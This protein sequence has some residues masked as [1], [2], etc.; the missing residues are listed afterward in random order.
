MDVTVTEGSPPDDSPALAALAAEGERLIKA[1]F[2]QAHASGKPDWQEMRS[3]VV[4]NRILQLAP[5]FDERAW[6]VKTFREFL[7]LFPQ[8][9]EVDTAARPPLVRL[10]EGGD[11]ST[12]QTSDRVMARRGARMRIRSDLWRAIM[13]VRDKGAY[14][15]DG[16]IA[17][18]GEGDENLRLPTATPDDLREWRKEFVSSALSEAGR[19]HMPTDQL[20]RWQDE[21]MSSHTLPA[22]I[23][24]SWI[25][26][27][28]KHVQERLEAWFSEKGIEA[29]QDLVT[30]ERRGVA[31][32]TEPDN[33]RAFAISAIE[34][35]TRSELEQLRL[36]VLVMLRCRQ[37]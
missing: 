8:L 6:G 32:D 29:P 19:A 26:D 37:R 14:Y 1:A 11:I 36:P 23:R 9:V 31:S 3:A 22:A 33:L 20:L 25:A 28:K 21:A 13:D 2:D 34:G 10:R 24:A 18:Q 15:W 17:Q 35:M 12:V 27:L 16:V 30:A 5:T 4:K 7:E